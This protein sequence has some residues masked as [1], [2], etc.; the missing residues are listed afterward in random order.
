MVYGYGLTSIYE[1]EFYYVSVKMHTGA[2]E[3]G[4]VG[5]VELLAMDMKARLSV[6]FDLSCSLSTVLIMLFYTSDEFNEKL[7]E[8]INADEELQCL[9]WKALKSIKR[10]LMLMKSYNVYY[11]KH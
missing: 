11:G 4:R 7:Q 6:S 2:Q 5:A 9:L 8:T 1:I 10:Q 3:K